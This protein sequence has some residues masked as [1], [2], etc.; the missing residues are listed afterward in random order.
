MTSFILEVFVY[1]HIWEKMWFCCISTTCYFSSF[2]RSWLW[3]G[4]LLFGLIGDGRQHGH[5]GFNVDIYVRPRLF[6][7][8]QLDSASG[9]EM[10]DCYEPRSALL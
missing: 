4:V 1:T 8:E 10:K 3:Y 9:L 7:L 5:V 6:K 2:L